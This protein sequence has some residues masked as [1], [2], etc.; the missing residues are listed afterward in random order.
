MPQSWICDFCSNPEPRWLYRARS[1]EF[2]E[3]DARSKADGLPV[4]FAL[5]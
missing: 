2:K 4:I 5:T 3:L 1:I